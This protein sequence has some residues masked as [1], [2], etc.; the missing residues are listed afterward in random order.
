M[1]T[2]PIALELFKALKE[3]LPYVS[4]A[5]CETG[6]MDAYNTELNAEKAIKMAEELTT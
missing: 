4:E 3:C 5:L 6:S 1:V 2:D